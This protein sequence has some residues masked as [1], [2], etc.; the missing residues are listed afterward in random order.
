[1]GTEKRVTNRR[2]SRRGTVGRT[3]GEGK[4]GKCLYLLFISLM[5]VLLS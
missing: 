5:S 2:G 1:M 3:E 4:E